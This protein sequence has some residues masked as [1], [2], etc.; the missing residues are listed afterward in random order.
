MSIKTW[1]SASE[2]PD[3]DRLV[4]FRFD[5]DGTT[6]SYMLGRYNTIWKRFERRLTSDIPW[7]Y[8][9]NWFVSPGWWRE[10]T[11]EER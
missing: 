9:Q 10:L 4:M 5:Y 8:W 3:T 11:E 1:Y 6:P 7:G 2:P